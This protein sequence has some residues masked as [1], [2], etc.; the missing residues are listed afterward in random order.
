MQAFWL[1]RSWHLYTARP[2]KGN[3]RADATAKAAIRNPLPSL[4]FR[5]PDPGPPTLQGKVYTLRRTVRMSEVSYLC[6]TG[7]DCWMTLPDTSLGTCSSTF[8][9]W[10]QGKQNSGELK[11]YSPTIFGRTNYLQVPYLQTYQRGQTAQR[12]PNRE[13]PNRM[14]IGKWTSLR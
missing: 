6:L 14:P 7:P 9:P 10:V 3:E 2:S 13:A 4:A 11:H 5:L 1:P 8:T 12:A